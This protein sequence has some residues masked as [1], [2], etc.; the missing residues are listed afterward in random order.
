[1]VLELQLNSNYK[2]NFFLE[3]HLAKN[4]SYAVRRTAPINCAGV[5]FG[6]LHCNAVC[7][8]SS[9]NCMNDFLLGAVSQTAPITVLSVLAVKL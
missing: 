2:P 3:L 6:K 8:C 5:Q 9:P 7:R 4:R 1:M